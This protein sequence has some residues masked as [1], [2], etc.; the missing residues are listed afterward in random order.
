MEKK[1]GK[2]RRE[3]GSHRLKREKIKERGFEKSNP[4]VKRSQFPTLVY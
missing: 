4:K 3:K 2:N 1:I